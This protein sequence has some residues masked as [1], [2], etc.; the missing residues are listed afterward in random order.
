LP[1]RPVLVIIV[2]VASVAQLVGRDSEA[3]C[4]VH[5]ANGTDA[6]DPGHDRRNTLRYCA[7]RSPSE[8]TKQG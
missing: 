8:T 7:P 6:A 5:P 2:G 4:A 1:A 3:Y